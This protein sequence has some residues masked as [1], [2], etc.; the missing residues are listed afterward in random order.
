MTHVAMTML[1]CTHRLGGLFAVCDTLG[2]GL[3]LISDSSIGVDTLRPA[4]ANV[5]VSRMLKKGA[6]DA[7]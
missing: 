1:D 6:A 2:T 3:C 5:V 7:K 4:T